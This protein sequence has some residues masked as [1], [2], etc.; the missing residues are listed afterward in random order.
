MRWRRQSAVSHAKVTTAE[1][2]MSSSAERATSSASGW[3]GG[4]GDAE[5]AVRG[6]DDGGLPA[7]VD[8]GPG[9]GFGN[10][11]SWPVLSGWRKL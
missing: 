8:E 4:R 11:G 2:S 5:D 1:P 6:G 10:R 9:D 3:N 7:E